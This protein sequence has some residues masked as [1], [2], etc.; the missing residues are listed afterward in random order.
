MAN[1][2]VGGSSFL[3]M[4]QISENRQLW[5]R[6]GSGFFSSFLLS[7]E[8]EGAV[9]EA[10]AWSQALSSSCAL[11]RGLSGRVGHGEG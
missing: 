7:L 4:G 3:L 9:G 8:A 1:P 5:A 6:C 11:P 10:R 2:G